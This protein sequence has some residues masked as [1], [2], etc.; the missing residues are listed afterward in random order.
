MTRYSAVLPAYLKDDDVEA[1]RGLGAVELVY[2]G[3]HRN[4]YEAVRDL[5]AEYGWRG[6][7][8]TFWEKALTARP[9]GPSALVRARAAE[10]TL[11]WLAYI[12]DDPTVPVSTR[13]AQISA[14]LKEHA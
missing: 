11:R 14:A 9:D 3:D 12:A 10:R 4:R 8:S 1:V 6:L 2:L 7:D 13:L 5:S